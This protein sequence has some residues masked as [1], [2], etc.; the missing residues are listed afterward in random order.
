MTKT[1]RPIIRMS[2]TVGDASQYLSTQSNQAGFCFCMKVSLW[3]SKLIAAKNRLFVQRA[4]NGPSHLKSARNCFSFNAHLFGPLHKSQ[5]FSSIGD[6]P[7]IEP[8][9]LLFFHGR[10]TTIVRF[11][12]TT[13]IN[14]IKRMCQ[15]AFAHIIKKILELAPS[16]TNANASRSILSISSGGFVQTSAEHVF[17]NVISSSTS[18]AMRGIAF[19]AYIS[20]LVTIETPARFGVTLT[21]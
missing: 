9:V 20:L 6:M 13:A 17:P 15:R 10:P 5:C 12:I 3:L 4:L 18:Q 8:V 11:I 7:V 1:T 2:G 19:Y 21:Q 14:T 16:L